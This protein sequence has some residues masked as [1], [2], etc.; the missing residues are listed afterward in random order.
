[1]E[2]LSLN[3]TKITYLTTLMDDKNATGK[4][5]RGAWDLAQSKGG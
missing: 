5:D 3:F 4:P 2:S 1:M